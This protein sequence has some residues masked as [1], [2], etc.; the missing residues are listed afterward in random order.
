VRDATT[1][2]RLTARILGHDHFLVELLLKIAMVWCSVSLA[3]V[4][5][6]L[7]YATMRVAC[8]REQTWISRF[9]IATPI[10]F[11]IEREL[12]EWSSEPGESGAQGQR[13]QKYLRF[14]VV[15]ALVSLPVFVI[16]AI[17]RAL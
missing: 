1:S 12:T 7:Q 6:V 3:L 10:S 4:T 17:T 14:S 8:R 15:S 16:A 11:R 9:L 2:C 5:L 13:I